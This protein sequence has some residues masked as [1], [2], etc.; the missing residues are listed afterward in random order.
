LNLYLSLEEKNDTGLAFSA[1]A[2]ISG[3]SSV[4]QVNADIVPVT[5]ST[6]DNSPE[7]RI[8]SHCI[9]KELDDFDGGYCGM[10]VVRGKACDI[11]KKAFLNVL[12]HGREQAVVEDIH[13]ELIQLE[14]PSGILDISGIRWLEI[15]TQEDLA[16]AE[17]I[18]KM[19]PHFLD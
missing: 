12:G 18:M 7:V 13:A 19:K 2:V 11:Y 8:F 3:N 1:S 5:G 15:D 17:R 14:A 9:K 16:N 6:K 10:T 4:E